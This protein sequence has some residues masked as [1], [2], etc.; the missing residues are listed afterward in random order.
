MR[1][2]LRQIKEDVAFRVL[3]YNN[4]FSYPIKPEKL[5]TDVRNVLDDDD[6][7]ISDVG[8]HKLWIAKVYNTYNPNTPIAQCGLRYRAQLQLSLPDQIGKLLQCVGMLDF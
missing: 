3:R 8:A 7:V 2:H 6:I 4:D 5:V 1:F